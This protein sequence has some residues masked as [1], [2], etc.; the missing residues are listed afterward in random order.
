MSE[1][2][3]ITL[4]E[5]IYRELRR[6]IITQKI[7][8]GKKITLQELKTQFGVSHTPIRDALTRLN[9]E[10]LVTYYSNCRINVVSFTEQDINELFQFAAELNAISVEFCKYSFSSS[11]LLF[12]LDEL[13]SL[14][15]R[16]IEEGDL[17]TYQGYSED[18]H[19]LFYKYA[20]N[21]Y[22]TEASR[23]IQAK[24]ALLSNLYYSDDNVGKIQKEH[25]AIGE[26]IH[27]GDYTK[28]ADLMRRHTQDDV[29]F[30]LKS[31][32]ERFGSPS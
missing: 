23:R 17:K 20:N 29:V 22:L 21:H 31:Y 13:L 27:K 26:L 28:A 15:D 8:C 12:E 10:G 2:N 7:P 9:E 32:R 3:K 19:L 5:Q 14:T 16:L 25:H 1:S 6:D 4:A 30:A 18:F 11:P 24:I